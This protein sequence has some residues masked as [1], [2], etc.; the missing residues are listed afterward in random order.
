MSKTILRSLFPWS[1]LLIYEFIKV[2]R[3]GKMNT[4]GEEDVNTSHICFS[5]YKN[6]GNFVGKCITDKYLIIKNCNFNPTLK[7]IDESLHEF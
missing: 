4:R 2:S 7:L 1:R 3:K 5:K 6:I